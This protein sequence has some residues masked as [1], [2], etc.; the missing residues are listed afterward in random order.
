M[1]QPA[2]GLRR[3]LG[4]GV[5][6]LYGLGMIVGAGIYVLIGQVA[7]EA[8]MAAPLSFL[9]AAALAGITGLSFAE[10]VARYP[11]AAAEVAY[12]D[13]A[14]GIR[15]LSAAVGIALVLATLVG[16]ATLAKGGAGY[17]REYVDL[18]DALLIA[19]SV[20]FF[21]LIAA[22]GVRTSAVAVAICT[23]IELAGLVFVIVVGF[24]AL[25][26]LPT[27]IGEMIPKDTAALGVALGGA[28][29]AFFAYLGFET[30]ANMAEETKRPERTLPRAMLLSVALAAVIY[31]LVALVAVLT[32]APAILAE[33]AAPLCLVVERAG[34]PCKSG[35]AAVALFGLANGI[36]AHIILIA[37][38]LYGMARRGLAPRQFGKVNPVSHVPLAATIVAGAA[39]LAAALLVPFENLVA[40]TSFITLSVFALVNAALWRLKTRPAQTPPALQVPL[41]APIVGC[42]SC[43]A[44]L[45]VNLALP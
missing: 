45:I 8:G 21:T 27:R 42:V 11:E 32:I 18:P 37:R 44:L 28:F 7:G 36:I 3:T 38:L 24:D 4:L 17:M 10:L 33:A 40:A 14:F 41:W 9:L 25:G 13:N 39:V 6:V 20:S 12:V 16:A 43:I 23:V 26:T 31:V 2:A 29:T 5:L 30:L 22:I 35:F 34:L 1:N 15:P 19:A